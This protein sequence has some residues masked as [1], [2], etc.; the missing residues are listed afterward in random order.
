MTA[1]HVMNTIWLQ[2]TAT[3]ALWLWRRLQHIWSTYMTAT[4]TTATHILKYVTATKICYCN[5]H[6]EHIWLQNTAPRVTAT[7]CTTH[8]CGAVYCWEYSVVCNLCIYENYRC[9]HICIHLYVY[10]WAITSLN[11][12]ANYWVATSSRLLKIIGLFCKRAL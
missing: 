12:F 2:H 7:H 4:H 1:T 9:I 11:M 3:A 5:S 8:M 6:D 10:R